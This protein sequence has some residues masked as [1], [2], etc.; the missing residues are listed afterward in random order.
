M[1]QRVE[2]SA[3]APYARLPWAA[4]VWLVRFVAEFVSDAPPG[5]GLIALDVGLIAAQTWAN[6]PVK[7]ALGSRFGQPHGRGWSWT[8]FLLWAWGL[9]WLAL[10][11]D[12]WFWYH[13]IGL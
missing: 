12:L 1:N 8:A 13:D 11:R 5:M 6:R 4:G 9:S 2:A 7:D 10:G 3:W